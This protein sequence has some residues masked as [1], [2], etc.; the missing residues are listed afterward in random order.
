V[1]TQISFSIIEVDWKQFCTT[2]FASF[3]P[4]Q[5]STWLKWLLPSLQTLWKRTP[6]WTP[7]HVN[8]IL[9]RLGHP[10]DKNLLSTIN[11]NAYW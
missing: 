9:W 5:C 8:V 7:S 1:E 3:P 6:L 11:K 2:V 4:P 10:I